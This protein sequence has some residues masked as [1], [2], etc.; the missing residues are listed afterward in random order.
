VDPLSREQL[1]Q[2][3]YY[4]DWSVKD[5]LAHLGCWFAEAAR[6]LGQ[7]RLR[8]YGGWDQDTDECNRR[9]YETWREQDLDAVWA[10]L[11][12]GRAR[13]LEEW[14]L[15]PAD[16]VDDTAERWFRESGWEHYE[17][18]LPRLREWVRELSGG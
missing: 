13:F 14:D 9:W 18:H 5:L 7:V 6:I 17:E 3:G 1:V 2:D 11:Y 15:L 12:S 8:T 10:E 4:P 16:R